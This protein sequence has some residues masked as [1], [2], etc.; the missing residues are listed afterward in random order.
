MRLRQHVWFTVSSDVLDHTQLTERIGIEPD[1]VK[2]RGS[3]HNVVANKPVPRSH[4]WRLI[5]DEPGINVGAQVERVLARLA[6]AREALHDLV[7]GEDD[8]RVVLH[9][10][11]HFGDEEGQEEV[12]AIFDDDG[13]VVIEGV[14]LFGW[15]LERA[16]LEFLVYVGAVLDVDEYDLLENEEESEPV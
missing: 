2:V 5:C 7:E 6:P 16:T 10:G 13:N 12:G 15:A 14:W 1:Q 3:R 8:V 11:R 9:V 4:A